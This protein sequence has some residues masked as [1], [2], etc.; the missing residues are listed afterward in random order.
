MQHNI[1]MF[2]CR[3]NNYPEADGL[4]IGDGAWVTFPIVKVLE[5]EFGRP[6][7]TNEIATVWHVCHLLDYWKPVSGYGRLLQSQ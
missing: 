3:S 2:N 6:V 1:D 4:Y 5:K 7:I